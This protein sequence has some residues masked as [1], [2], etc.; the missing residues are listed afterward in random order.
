MWWWWAKANNKV[1]GDRLHDSDSTEATSLCIMPP[2]QQVCIYG[3]VRKPTSN[4]CWLDSP[5][6]TVLVGERPWVTSDKAKL[7]PQHVTHPKGKASWKSKIGRESREGLGGGR[8]DMATLPSECYTA[9]THTH[10][11][12]ANTYTRTVI[13]TDTT[14]HVPDTF[15]RGEFILSIN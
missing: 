5:H 12:T 7:F 13:H 6:V 4:K 2:E 10:T 3:V 1:C 14:I 8:G 9:R 15:P 11:H